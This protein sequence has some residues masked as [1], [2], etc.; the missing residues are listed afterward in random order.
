[1]ARF[2]ARAALRDAGVCH[3]IS[4]FMRTLRLAAAT[5]VSPSEPNGQYLRQ[6]GVVLRMLD[7]ESDDIDI[8]PEIRARAAHLSALD[9]AAIR[10]LETEL[11][12]LFDVTNKDGQT[13]SC[14]VEFRDPARHDGGKASVRG[15]PGPRS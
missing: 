8:G 2:A 3:A 15:L 9:G 5:R 13:P 4:A 1:V 6:L 12:S 10:N 7:R 11:L 14:V